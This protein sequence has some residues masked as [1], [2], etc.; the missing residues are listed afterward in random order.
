MKS[1]QNNAYAKAYVKKCK[2]ALTDMSCWCILCQARW[3][4]KLVTVCAR[5]VM[6]RKDFIASLLPNP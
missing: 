6:Q 5:R 1:I 2:N 4:Y 3:V